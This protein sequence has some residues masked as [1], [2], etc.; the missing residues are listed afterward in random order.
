MIRS[1]EDLEVYQLSYKL[2]MEIFHLSRK[3]RKEEIYSLTSQVIGKMLTKLH[4]NWKKLEDRTS[5]SSSN[6]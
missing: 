4:D 6:L 3:F 2:A 1:F 5:V